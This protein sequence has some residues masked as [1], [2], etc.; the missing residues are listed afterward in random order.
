MAA[1]LSSRAEL[2][3]EICDHQDQAVTERAKEAFATL[4]RE[5]AAEREWKT[6]HSRERDERFE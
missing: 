1:I 3:R 4:Q 5:I 2:L 6:K